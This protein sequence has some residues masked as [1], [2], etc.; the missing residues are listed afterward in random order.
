MKVGKKEILRVIR[1]DKEKGRA[2]TMKAI[3]IFPR[4]KLTL[5]TRR[6]AKKNI[7]MPLSFILYLSISQSFVRYPF[8]CSIKNTYG[9]CINRRSMAI[10]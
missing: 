6:K 9:P 7:T 8:L 10:P 2:S 4:N 5:T 1:V 3:L